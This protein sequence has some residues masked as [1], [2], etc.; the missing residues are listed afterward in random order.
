MCQDII[1]VA[2]LIDKV[3]NLAGLSR[4]CEV[5]GVPAFAVYAR[6]APNLTPA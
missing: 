3:P 6:V 1:V 2:S 4:T 5:R